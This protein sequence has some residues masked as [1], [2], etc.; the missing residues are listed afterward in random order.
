MDRRRARKGLGSKD[1]RHSPIPRFRVCDGRHRLRRCGG[2]RRRRHLEVRAGPARLFPAEELR[3]AGDDARSRGRRQSLGRICARAAPL[4]AVGGDS[5]V[6]QE[7]LHRRR[8]Q[9]LLFPSRLRPRGHPARRSCVSAGIEARPRRFDDHPTGRQELLADFGSN[10]RAQDPRNS[11][12]PTYRVGLF[13]GQDPRTLSQRNLS[14]PEQL[15]GRRRRAQ[16]LQQVGARI[17]DCGSRLSRRF[18]QGAERA[19]SVPQPRPRHRAPQLC[20]QP[21]G[22]GWLHHRRAGESGARRAAD[23]HASSAADQ[24]DRRRFFRRG[25]APRIVRALRRAEALRGRLVGAHHAGFETAVDG[26][27]G[28]G[29][30]PGALRRG[31]WLARH[32]QDDRSRPG[33]GRAARRYS[34]IRRHQAL[35]SR[36]GPRRRRYVDA[37][38]LA[39]RT[40]QVRG[41]WTRAR[42]GHGERR[43]HEMDR[44]ETEGARQARRRGLHRTGCRQ[45]GRVPAAP[46]PRSVGRLRRDGSVHRPRP[47]DGRRLLLRSIGIQSRHPGAAPAR[48]LVQ[49]VRLRRGARQ[50]LYAVLDRSR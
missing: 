48:L 9:E 3:T 16:L 15:R 38:R 20:D 8:G 36:G 39:A 42:N 35:A 49:A 23:H 14:R 30:W 2:R 33:L 27:Q 1:A 4:S 5:A 45:G 32:G 26:A 19:Q 50:R 41:A 22:G 21:H 47:G 28:A 37:H 18:A 40:R 10:L 44:A 31:S 7:R 11:A 24:L 25:G 6:G 12:E 29:R 17:I 13:Q 34:R 46:D 43:R